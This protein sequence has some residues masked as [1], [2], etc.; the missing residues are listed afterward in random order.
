MLL[1]MTDSPMREPTFLVLTA[2]AETPQHGYAV[3]EDVLR[4]SDGRVRLRAGTLYAVLDRLRADGLI[5][6]D[7]EEVVQS[8]L[9][10]YYRLTALGA[11][12]LADEVARLRRNADAANRRL[13]RAGLLPQGGTA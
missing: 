6:V 1:G 3:I 8:R 10:R 9:R 2:L 12:R 7:R 4:I 13:R 5:E 11:A